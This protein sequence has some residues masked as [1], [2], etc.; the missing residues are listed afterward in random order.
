MVAELGGPSC[1][2]PTGVKGYLLQI[3]TT[4]TIITHK[5]SYWDNNN[6][7]LHASKVSQENLCIISTYNNNWC[8]F[9]IQMPIYIIT[10][11]CLKIVKETEM[12]YIVITLTNCCL[13]IV[14]KGSNWSSSLRRDQNHELYPSHPTIINQSAHGNLL[15]DHFDSHHVMQPN[16]PATINQRFCSI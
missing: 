10:C 5:T 16:D 1:F 7:L 13:G 8:V 15:P 3:H 2:A 11:P 4:S 6:T 12:V 14:N 9:S